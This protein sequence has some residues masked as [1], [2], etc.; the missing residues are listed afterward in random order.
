MRLKLPALRIRRPWRLFVIITLLTAP[1][2][3][4]IVTRVR[5]GRYL[6]DRAFPL[7][8][9]P[10]PELGYRYK[11]SSAGLL[12]IPNLCRKVEIN[13]NGYVGPP[14]SEKK[15]PGDYRIVVISHSD[16]TGIWT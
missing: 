5:Y 6:R 14:F 10:D 15:R 1:V 16:G 3:A 9:Q 12:C 4:E 2:V 13:A 8:Y 7:I 11:P